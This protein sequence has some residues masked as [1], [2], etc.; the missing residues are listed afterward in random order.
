VAG[1]WSI[2]DGTATV[3]GGGDR[4]VVIGGGP[5]DRLTEATLTTVQPGA[6]IAFRYGNSRI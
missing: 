1:S 3:S 4:L 6:G 2:D 5:S